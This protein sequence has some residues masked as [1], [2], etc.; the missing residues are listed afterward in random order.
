M[1]RTRTTTAADRRF[2]VFFASIGTGPV[3][4][5]QSYTVEAEH[6]EAAELRA[7][8][9]LHIDF[10]GELPDMSIS[11]RAQDGSRRR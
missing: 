6:D 11:C 2:D 7:I 9:M 4:I 10:P 8:E 1:K 3:R 5:A